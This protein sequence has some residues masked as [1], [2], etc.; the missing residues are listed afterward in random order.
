MP[1]EKTGPQNPDKVHD[2]RD[3][4]V[5]KPSQAEGDV[6]DAG[7]ADDAGDAA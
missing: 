3:D 5:D 1:A 2:G 7:P 4:R 6:D